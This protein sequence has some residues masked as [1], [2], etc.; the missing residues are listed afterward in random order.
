MLRVYPDVVVC[1]IEI[2]WLNLELCPRHCLKIIG[3]N[4]KLESQNSLYTSARV[5]YACQFHEM[6]LQL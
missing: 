2:G 3:L 4:P 6:G 1:K 5:N